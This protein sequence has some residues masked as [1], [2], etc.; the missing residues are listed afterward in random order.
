MTVKEYYI[1][2]CQHDWWYDYSDDHSVWTKGFETNRKLRDISDESQ[3]HK[4]LWLAF[5]NWKMGK[6]EK[7]NEP[8]T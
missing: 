2:L 7:P 3:Q 4:K 6:G 5:N 8:T 1:A